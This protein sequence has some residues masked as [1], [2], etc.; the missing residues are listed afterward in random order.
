MSDDSPWVPTHGPRP[1]GQQQCAYSPTGR[2]ADYCPKSATW[3]VMWDG[4]HNNSLT[5]DEHM[6]LIQARWLYDDRHP[7]VADCNMP[8]ALWMYKLKRCDFPTEPG[9]ASAARQE[10]TTAGG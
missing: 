3:H 6:D 5:C 9:L 2:E 7:V 8:G 4:N 10:P 1:A